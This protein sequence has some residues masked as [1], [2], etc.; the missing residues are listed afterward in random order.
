MSLVTSAATGSDLI[1]RAFRAVALEVLRDVHLGTA[2]EIYNAHETD[3]LAIQTPVAIREPHAPE[4]RSDGASARWRHPTHPARSL[5]HPAQP[6]YFRPG[7]LP[8]PLPQAA[9][10]TLAP[11]GASNGKSPNSSRSL[12]SRMCLA[13]R[14]YLYRRL[15][16]YQYL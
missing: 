16:V 2:L 15:P 6:K 7:P 13:P 9:M 8:G 11:R 4:T 12:E 3:L 1:E 14:S 5:V 10:T